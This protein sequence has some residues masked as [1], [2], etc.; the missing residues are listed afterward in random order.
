MHHGCCMQMI[1]ATREPSA[2]G[3]LVKGSSTGTKYGETRLRF[4][5]RYRNFSVLIG[6]L[7]LY[8]ARLLLIIVLRGYEIFELVYE[9]ER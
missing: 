3:S 2:R 8:I 4:Y 7:S 1:E 5:D 6:M 9:R